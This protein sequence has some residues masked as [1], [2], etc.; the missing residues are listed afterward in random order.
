MKICRRGDNL[1]INSH[2]QGPRVWKIRGHTLVIILIICFSLWFSIYD[3][4]AAEYKGKDIDG[5]RYSCTAYSYSTGR[6]YYGTVEFNGDEAVLYLRNLGRV[7]LTLDN[8]EI[9]DPSSI[10]A[11]DYKRGAYWELDVDDLD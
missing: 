1:P 9:D 8:E 7:V 5:E 2:L 10:E 3:I 11:Y 6:W 4:E